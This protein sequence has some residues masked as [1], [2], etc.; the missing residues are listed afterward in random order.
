ALLADTGWAAQGGWPDPYTSELGE[1][2]VAW[3]SSVAARLAHGA[4]LLIDYGFPRREYYHPQRATG[5][6]ICHYRHHSHDDPLWL[7]GLQDITSHVDFPAVDAAARAAGL[8]P[9][10]YASQA[11]FLIGCD[12]PQLAM[13]ISPD[14]PAA[15]ARQ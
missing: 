11:S 2:A 3:V 13:Q 14:E 5:T 12:L 10:G 8:A 1:Q 7:P 15:W 6:L 9:L 4:M